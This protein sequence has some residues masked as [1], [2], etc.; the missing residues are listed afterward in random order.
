MKCSWIFRNTFTF[1]RSFGG[2]G[3]EF[4]AP[5]WSLHHNVSSSNLWLNLL[6]RTSLGVRNV[7]ASPQSLPIITSGPSI[8]VM[9]TY[10][11][12]QSFGGHLLITSQLPSAVNR[13]NVTNTPTAGDMSSELPRHLRT[14]QSNICLASPR[15]GFEATVVCRGIG[16]NSP[17]IRISL[18]RTETSCCDAKTVKAR[19]DAR[20]W[21]WR[22]YLRNFAINISKKR[23]RWVLAIWS[24]ELTN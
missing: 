10:I 23:R 11:A 7:T 22:S 19:K 2:E 14:H 17:Y 24:T 5:A 9:E 4:A 16:E 3:G 1:L 12:L 20:W 21:D 6:F 13:Q 15:Y 18:P 8:C